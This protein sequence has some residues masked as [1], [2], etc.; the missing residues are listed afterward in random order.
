M[1]P[2]APSRMV[3][4]WAATCAIRTLVADDAIDG[5]LWCSAYQTLR[6]PSC[7]ACL[8][9]TTVA[10]KL[11]RTD[12]LSPTIARSRMDSGGVIETRNHRARTHISRPPDREALPAAPDL[13]ANHPGRGMI[14]PPQ[15]G[16]A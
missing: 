4:V 11:S 1:T 7:S 16:R 15:H 6:N 12:C 9:S 8:A 13:Q 2:P 10:S 5:M 3:W 14:V